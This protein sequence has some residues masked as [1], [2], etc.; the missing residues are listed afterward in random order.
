MTAQPRV[1]AQRLGIVMAL[2]AGPTLVATAPAAEAAVAP[3]A[4]VTKA[5]EARVLV[6][7]NGQRAK[8]GR[9][10]LKPTYCPTWFAQRWA[11]NL[12]RTGSFSHQSLTPI[13]R[14]CS[15]R[16]AAENM[17]LGNVS[18]DRFLDL[19]MASPSHRANI[20]DPTLTRIGVSAVYANGKWT[21]VTDFTRS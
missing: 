2:F 18:A 16:R 19:W 10:A 5:Y 21:V 4:A 11:A 12:A 1:F 15:A 8:Y 14:V 13:L 3:S 20:L 7:I 6:L 9:V 17:A